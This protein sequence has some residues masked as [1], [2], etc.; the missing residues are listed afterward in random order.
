MALQDRLAVAV[1]GVAAVP[2][3]FLLDCRITSQTSAL[4]EATGIEKVLRA[5]SL[6]G[7]CAT[8]FT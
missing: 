6:Q 3:T 4:H 5:N 2:T 8:A 1:D 7:P